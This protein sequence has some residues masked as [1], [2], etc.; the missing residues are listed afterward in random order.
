MSNQ[1]DT[2]DWYIRQTANDK[3]II[4]LCDD[5]AGGHTP[6]ITLDGSAAQTQVDMDFYFTDNVKAKF[7]NSSDLEIYHDGTHTYVD[8]DC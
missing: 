3:D 8:N 5:G 4:I 7:G 1:N 6:Y 2:G